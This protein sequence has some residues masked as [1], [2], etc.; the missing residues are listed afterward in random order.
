MNCQKYGRGWGHLKQ[1]LRQCETKPLRR[2]RIGYTGARDSTCADEV[3]SCCA[4]RSDC[5]F[6]LFSGGFCP[7]DAQSRPPE[8]SADRYSFQVTDQGILRLIREPDRSPNVRWARQERSAVPHRTSVRRSKAE[9]ARLE[10]DNTV[11]RKTARGSRP[12]QCAAGPANAYSGGYR[13]ISRSGR[14]QREP[15]TRVVSA[16]LSIP[17]GAALSR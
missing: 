12:D 4:P 6:G 10:A 2:A 16:P 14:D 11:L 7:A 8:P 1:L 15:T 9:I 13:P 3:T 17:R 5:V